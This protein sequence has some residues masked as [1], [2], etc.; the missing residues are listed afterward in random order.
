MLKAA[1]L[2]LVMTV[3][4]FA[5]AGIIDN[6]D[7]TTVDGLD[8]LDFSATI[9]M[10]QAIALNANNGWRTATLDEMENMMNTMFDTTFSW[11]DG[12]ISHNF[13]WPVLE[14]R[15][16]LFIELFGQTD[17]F[18]PQHFASYATVQGIGL[19]GKDILALAG[20]GLSYADVGYASD[21]S[22]IALVRS[23]LAVPEPSTL[24]IFALGLIGLASRRLAPNL[25]NNSEQ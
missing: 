12:P 13:N 11:E 6:G 19:V 20:L 21:R 15:T 17:V 22:G 4:G 7:Y 10:T 18:D 9:G 25:C 5:S 8:W 16:D 24:A 23:A 2:G 14:E 3:S 1:L